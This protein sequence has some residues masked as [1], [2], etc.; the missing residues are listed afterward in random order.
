MNSEWKLVKLKDYTDKIAS[1]AT[2]RGGSNVYFDIGNYCLIRSQNIYNKGFEASGL[3]YIDDEAA[4]KLKNVDIFKKDILLN[5]TGD[6]VARVCIA[7][8]DYLPARVNQHVALIRLKHD[9]FD[10]R[11]VRYFLT[12]NKMQSYMLSLA[13][14]GGTRNALT[15]GMIENFLIPKPALSIQKKIAH[16]LS[17]LDNKIEL[18]KKINQTLESIAQA[19]FKSWFV[20]FDPVHAKANAQSEDEYDAIAKELGISREILDLFPSEFEESEVGLIPKGWE[21]KSLDQVAHFQNGLALQKFRP[22]GNS[23]LPVLKI[24]QL[25]RGYCDDEEKAD[26]NIKEECIV[27]SGDVIFSWSG[28]LIVDI[29]CSGKAALNQHLF[30]VTSNTF[31]KWFYYFW[32][33]EHLKKFQAIAADKAVTMGHIKRSHLTEAKCLIPPKSLFFKVDI[34]IKS[35]IDSLINTR[36]ENINLERYKE[37]LLPKLLSGE[38]DVSNLNL[39]PEHD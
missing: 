38:I 33:V 5:I 28:S 4:K 16:I 15:K 39:G 7:P 19:I 30:K 3:V 1:G 27:D 22:K 36:L 8:E 6:S 9:E 32:V 34:I 25:K 13:S 26:V 18:N 21:I 14:S 31:P 11:F 2:P 20:D 37:K 24:A 10:Y 12:S 35:L 29:W 23:F 17:T